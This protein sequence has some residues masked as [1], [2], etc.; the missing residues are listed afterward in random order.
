MNGENSETDGMVR[1]KRVTNT[2]LSCLCGYLFFTRVF[3]SE[4]RRENNIDA[5]AT[6][7]HSTSVW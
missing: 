2:S 5:V 7:G 3:I 1:K 6:H 4:S